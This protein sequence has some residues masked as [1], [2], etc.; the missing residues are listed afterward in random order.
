[1]SVVVTN[2]AE[3]K[4]SEMTFCIAI[5]RYILMVECAVFFA[6]VVALNFILNEKLVILRKFA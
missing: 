3:R 5:I 6:L 2:E 4:I 1:M